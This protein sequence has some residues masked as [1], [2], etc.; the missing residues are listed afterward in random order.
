MY[1]FR[2]FRTIRAFGRDIYE[3]KITL[4]EANE[5]QS[6]LVHDINDF[7]KK[8][9]PQNNNKKQKKELFLKPCINF[10]RQEKKFSKVLKVKYF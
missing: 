3:G 5:D 2:N 7:V 4:E 10:L 9:R 8:K 6:K 1:D